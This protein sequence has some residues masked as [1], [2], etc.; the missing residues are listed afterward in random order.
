MLGKGILGKTETMMSGKPGIIQENQKATAIFEAARHCRKEKERYFQ[1]PVHNAFAVLLHGP[2]LQ[3]S[4]AY[5]HLQKYT[6]TLI[7]FWNFLNQYSLCI[8]AHECM[9]IVWIYFTQHFKLKENKKY[10]L[11]ARQKCLVNLPTSSKLT[12]NNIN[13]AVHGKWKAWVSTC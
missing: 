12:G 5:S 2:A 4:H 1:L 6:L 3:S 9:H 11:T 13:S 10:V 7:Q 8:Y